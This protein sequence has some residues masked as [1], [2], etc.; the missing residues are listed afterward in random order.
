METISTGPFVMRSTCR[1][2]HGTRL[3]NKN[4]CKECSGKGSTQQRKTIQ[5]PVPAGVEDGQ[6]IRMNAGN[7]ELYITF[8]VAKSE[9]F[10]RDGADVHTDADISL[11]QALL[12][13]TVDIQGLFEDVKLK[14]PAGTSSHTRIRLAN[15]GMKRISSYGHGD[16]YVHLKIKIPQYVFFKY[17]F[18]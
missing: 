10:R 5:I 15:K 14:I 13:G 16:H 12:G 7:K 17:N 9:Y 18:S 3:Y 1:M 2:C 8:R 11:S 6:T 4:P